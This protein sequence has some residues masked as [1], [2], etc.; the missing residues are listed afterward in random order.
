MHVDAS[1]LAVIAVLLGGAKLVGDLFGRVNLPPVL[2]EI[3][4]GIVLGNLHLLGWHGLDGIGTDPQLAL[5][6][7]L[8]VVLLL[9][10]VGL[11][12]NL[13]QM[14]RV[15]ASAFA[16]A[17]I[18]V[19]V[20]MGLGFGLHAAL[21]PEATWHVHLFIG[22]VL[23]ATSVG[24]TARVFKDL[25]RVDSPT[26]RVVLGAAVIDDVL[27]LIVLA[28][29]AGVVRGADS[30][31]DLEV[32]GIALIV[33]KAVGFL[34]AA[35]VL[36]RPVSRRLYR[37]AGVLRIHG[38]LLASTLVFCFAVAYLAD[39]VGLAPIVGAF[40][41]GLVLDELVYR[42]LATR[43]DRPLETQ[44]APIAE[45][46]TPIFFVLTG[47]QVDLAG[48]ADLHTLALAGALTFAAVIGKQACA[49]VAFGD[50]VHRLSVGLGMIPRG[51]VGLIFA[52][53]GAQLV[54]HG[55]AVVSPETYSAIVIMVM[56]TS[57]M[58]PPLLAWSIRRST[59]AGSTR[60][61]PRI[62]GAET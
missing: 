61:L 59:D 55:T 15:G 35:I 40:G 52:A 21:A 49:L 42:D 62:A 57:M 33:V 19:V 53:T 14:A 17:T 16:V 28:V 54:V 18:G 58:T 5:M 9:F 56:A 8:G 47:A 48:F 46:L 20:P 36:G 32:G 44:L 23:S 30:G 51:E 6:A 60:E 24:I 3:T 50:G 27:G 10:Q 38:V 45:V 37:A 4:A 31:T 7:E 43:E 2:G 13:H 29:V 25:G 1:L 11:E 12:S 41:A 39:L 26:G 34:G 22:A